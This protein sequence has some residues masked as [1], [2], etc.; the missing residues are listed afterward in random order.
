MEGWHW[1]LPTCCP[2]WF[3][4]LLVW[5]VPP[6]GVSVGKAQQCNLGP[7]WV[8]AF[9]RMRTMISCH[10]DSQRE[11]A[12]LSFRSS[13]LWSCCGL[14]LFRVTE[15][16]GWAPVTKLIGPDKPV[17]Q[18]SSEKRLTG[19]AGPTNP[20]DR[21]PP[22]E[23]LGPRL[24]WKPPSYSGALENSLDG[25]VTLCTCWVQGPEVTNAVLF[26]SDPPVNKMIAYHLLSP[27]HLDIL[28][29]S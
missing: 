19:Q 6:T 22:I 10:F 12:I 8:S 28:M 17:P 5:D 7:D 16:S 23:E 11:R 25:W 27:P 26:P 24:I 20:A 14:A 29:H 2:I 15:E 18:S 3:Y 13:L 1:N 21:G 9:R 4:F